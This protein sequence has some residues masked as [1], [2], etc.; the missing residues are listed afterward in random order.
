[1]KS[2]RAAVVGSAVA[3]SLSSFLTLSSMQTA[4]ARMTVDSYGNKT[5]HVKKK[6]ATTNVK[7]ATTTSMKRATTNTTAKKKR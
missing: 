3:L 5:V 6:P 7:R 2:K 4:E 1:M